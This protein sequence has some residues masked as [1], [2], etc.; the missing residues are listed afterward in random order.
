MEALVVL[1]SHQISR[2]LRLSGDLSR[3]FV[4]FRSA[5]T[6]KSPGDEVLMVF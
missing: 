6:Q 2:I 5:T 3:I 4:A 1:K